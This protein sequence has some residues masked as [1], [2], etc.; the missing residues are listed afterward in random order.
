MKQKHYLI[1]GGT[2]GIG[3]EIVNRLS[4]AGHLVSVISRGLKNPDFNKAT[5]ELHTAD[6]TD[7]SGPLPEITREIDGIVYC[8]GSINL[9]PFRSLKQ[10][11]FLMDLQVNLLGAVRVL[12]TYMPN[13]QKSEQPAVVLF[14]T[15]A[16][17]TGMAFHTSVAAAK[18]AV[19]G[20]AR[21]LAAESAPKIR[22]NVIA[23]SITETPLAEKFLN[24]EAKKTASVERH[25]LKRIGNA[26]EIAALAGFLLSDESSFIT[27]QVIHAD[28]GLSVLK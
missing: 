22:V 23:P 16:S 20:F 10:E 5:I 25:P 28:G 3:F 21:A 18:G 4:A 12:Q 27:G 19:E 24:S 1:I 15:V 17:G 2:S 7:T 26:A 13:L 11:D 9:K 6:V 8:P 14:S